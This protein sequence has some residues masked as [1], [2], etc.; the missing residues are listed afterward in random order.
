MPWKALVKLTTDS[1]PVILRASYLARQLQRRLDRVGA[2]RAGEHHLV[3]QA[4]RSQHD[5]AEGGQELPF[6]H[7]AHVQRVH[8]AVIGEVVQQGL[9]EDGVVVAVVEG[10]RARE[11]V[12]VLVAVLVGDPAA[13]GTVEDRGP[14]TA[15]AADF[16][17][18]RLEHVQLVPLSTSFPSGSSSPVRDMAVP[19]M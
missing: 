2:G 7:R 10:A 1:R 18:E 14:V 12:D 17:F 8:D 3:V 9:S 13:G 11:E 16:R 4:A 6:G 5:V 19:G 15:V